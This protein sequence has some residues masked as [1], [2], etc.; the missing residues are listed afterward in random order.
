MSVDAS[1]ESD[2]EGRLSDTG[3]SDG[4]LGGHSHARR[5]N[6][7]HR[8]IHQYSITGGSGPIHVQ[9]SA[10]AEHQIALLQAG[11]EQLRNEIERK[12]STIFNLRFRSYLEALAEAERQAV[13]SQSGWST[14]KSLQKFF[15]KALAKASSDSS[16]PLHPV[17]SGYSDRSGQGTST[18]VEETAK[19][20][21]SHFSRNIH[22]Y[23][24]S[25]DDFGL[26][27]NLDMHD[28]LLAELLTALVP[29]CPRKDHGRVDGSA[30]RS[31]FV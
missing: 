19:K 15:D 13:P 14:T 31:R 9:T 26:P 25:G 27:R 28:A 21:Y 7:G 2:H 5:E 10:N 23:F 18:Q 11:N 1:Q 30:E 22:K 29:K 6:K 24:E 17:Q 16:H 4:D 12:D 8:T 3:E 20:L